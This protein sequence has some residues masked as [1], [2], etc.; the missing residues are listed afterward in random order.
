MSFNL[1]SLKSIV[2]SS[3]SKPV[4]KSFLEFVKDKKPKLW[5]MDKEKKLQ[6][7]A[8]LLAL[9][10][11]I[12]GLS[13]RDLLQHI[14]PELKWKSNTVHHNQRMLRHF[15]YDWS[16]KIMVKDNWKKYQKTK[17]KATESKF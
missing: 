7:Y 15:M 16:E 8:V 12:K 9:Y 13:Y 4:V 3:L 5:G 11:D 14:K 1:R 2:Q 17:L 10:K 6:Q